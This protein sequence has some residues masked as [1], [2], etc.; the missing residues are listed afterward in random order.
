MKEGE[1]KK[2]KEKKQKD[3]DV[4][5]KERAI[6]PVTTWVKKDAPTLKLLKQIQKT[7]LIISK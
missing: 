7:V 4:K 5:V 2:T 1:N 6:V 3:Y